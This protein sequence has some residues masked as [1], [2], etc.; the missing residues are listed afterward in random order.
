MVMS[1][2]RYLVRIRG[3][4]TPFG[5]FAGVAPLRF[6]QEASVVWTGDQYVRI[7]A[8]AVWLA[9]VIARLESCPSLR[10]R[11]PVIV[12]DLVYVRGDRLVVPW[13]PHSGAADR[14]V[15]A[16]VSVRY[17]PAVQ[18]TMRATRS[19][20]LF[21]DLICELA[22]EVPGGP[23]AAIEGMLADLVTCGVLITGLRPPSTSTDGLA[24]VLD[25]IQEAKADTLD[26]VAPL[27]EELCMIR[28]LLEAASCGAAS[29]VG[30]TGRV[31]G[32]RMRALSGGTPQ[33]LMVDLRLG[34]TVVL[35][36]RVAAEAEAAA[37]ALL[38]LTATPTGSPAW[39]DYHTRFLNRYGGPG[40]MVPVQ[41]LVDVTAGLGFPV[42]YG[43]SGR[44]A[45]PTQLTERDEH[46]LALAQQAALDG[47]QEVV[48]DDH[49]ID[50]LAD[51]GTNGIR[52]APHVELCAEVLAPTM[53]AVAEGTFILAVTGVSRSAAAMTGRFLD[54]LPGDDR[55]RMIRGY[56]DLPVGINGAR[57]VQLSFPPKHSRTENVARAPRL[58]PEMICLAEYRDDTVDRIALEDL[59]VTADHDRLYVMSLSR[60]RVVESMAT[61]ATAPHTMPPIARLL[62][63]IPRAWSATVSPFDWGAADCLPFLPRLRYGRSVLAPARWRI[64]AGELPG[65]DTSWPAWAAAM[66]AVRARLRLPA[67]VQVGGSARW[68]RLNLD[69]AMDLAVLRTHLGGA[70]DTVTVLEAPTARDHG[71][72]G[73]RAHEIIIPLASTTPSAPAPTVVTKPGPLPLIGREHGILPGS[74]V[75]FAKVYGHPEGFDQILTGHLPDLL[76]S[77]EQ[78]PMWWFVRYRDPDPHLRLRLHLTDGD[79]GPAAARVGPWAT[80]LRRCGLIGDL[81]LDTYHPETPRYGSGAALAAAEAVFAADSAAVLAQLTALTATCQVHPYALTAASLVD[82]ASALAGSLPAGMRWLIEHPETGRACAYDREVLRQAISLADEDGAA[83]QAI[84]GGPQITAAWQVRRQATATYADRLASDTSY[85][86][87]VSVLRSLLHVH[88]VRAYGINTDSE[89]PCYRLAR[90]VALAWT[91]RHTTAPAGSR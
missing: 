66:A 9:G 5:V 7:R 41:Q 6:G 69:E 83:L 75:L 53:T 70:A 42:H 20:I 40:G 15:P 14:S 59:A 63:E 74:R 2:A 45:I 18:T 43:L 79:Y 17:S 82:L 62:L 58:L 31:T 77:W 35:P 55:Q 90:A 12:N 65:S 64:R 85:V 46:L 24:Y 26:E 91:A 68:L 32:G 71:W 28:A 44:P 22:S 57:P 50:A 56:G 89:R 84:P 27:V 78:P 73:G 72:L 23:A 81:T 13:Q 37:G 36:S 86:S 34:C 61:N 48:L 25:R 52:P 16:Q 67:T 4:A 60:H 76:S 29:A 80:E 30:R 54:L 3:R 8:D 1:L 88:H 10:R 38:R 87:S 51:G 47:A 19:P 49:A 21:D 39:R 11:L 33:P